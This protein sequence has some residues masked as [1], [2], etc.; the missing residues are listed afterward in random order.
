MQRV[1]SLDPDVPPA[2]RSHRTDSQAAEDESLSS[3]RFLEKLSDHVSVWLDLKSTIEVD[4]Q[5]QTFSADFFKEFTDEQKKVFDKHSLQPNQFLNGDAL[6]LTVY[7]ALTVAKS[8][9]NAN[10]NKVS[11][12]LYLHFPYNWGRS[13]LAQSVEHQT[14]NLAVAGSSAALG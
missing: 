13:R 8:S 10:I 7:A 9:K 12:S 4:E 14:L 1:P 5:I 3:K 11:F 2:P 6:Y